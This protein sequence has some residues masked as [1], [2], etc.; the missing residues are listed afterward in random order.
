MDEDIFNLFRRDIFSLRKLEDVLAAIEDT[1]RAVRVDDA[2][3]ARV[4]VALS[5]E[6]FGRLVRPLEVAREHAWTANA[7]LA[8]GERLICDAVIH[9]R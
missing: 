9:I 7:N 3:V 4:Q 5:I 2:D 1:N 8:S 6:R